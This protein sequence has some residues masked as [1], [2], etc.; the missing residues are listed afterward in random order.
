MATSVDKVWI[1]KTISEYNRGNQKTLEQ[2]A[3]EIIRHG[4]F[5]PA[6][7]EF[8]VRHLE[9]SSDQGGIIQTNATE[10][11][12][13][14][15]SMPAEA[16]RKT[17]KLSGNMRTI[18]LDRDGKAVHPDDVVERL[19]S[20]EDGPGGSWARDTETEKYLNANG[21]KCSYEYP[22]YFSCPC[23]LGDLNVGTVDG[24]WGADIMDKD[25]YSITI[26]E[27]VYMAF[28]QF[29]SKQPGEVT[30]ENLLHAIKQVLSWANT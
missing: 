4:R 17:L 11:F 19:L 10:I 15:A 9:V 5:D 13:L 24:F 14:F 25:G 8:L 28:D 30:P 16:P 23:K 18:D 26:P 21:V 27:D 2:V 22:G 29:R 12:D 7:K 1:N 20:E 3:D 6:K